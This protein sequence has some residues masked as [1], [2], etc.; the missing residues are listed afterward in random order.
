MEVS[1]FT[2][3]HEGAPSLGGPRGSRG[4]EGVRNPNPPRVR[5]RSSRVPAR[6]ST[7]WS[8][9]PGPSTNVQRPSTRGSSRRSALVGR[10][11]LRVFANNQGPRGCWGRAGAG[12]VDGLSSSSSSRFTEAC[13]GAAQPHSRTAAWLKARYL[14]QTFKKH[15]ETLKHTSSGDDDVTVAEHIGQN[16]KASLSVAV[17]DGQ[18]QVSTQASP[19][20][21]F[22]E[23]LAVSLWYAFA[24]A[25]QGVSNCDVY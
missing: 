9:T 16:P 7:R 24:K 22:S 20:L 8:R 17:R 19:W 12:L 14:A 2:R 25:A 23:S 13:C 15:S 3:R 18:D 11:L 1:S 5:K 4:H 10:L 6:S 21:S